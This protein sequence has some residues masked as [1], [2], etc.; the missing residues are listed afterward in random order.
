MLKLTEYERIMAEKKPMASY[1]KV[2][3]EEYYYDDR[4]K[5]LDAVE[6]NILL[7]RRFYIKNDIQ[8]FRI[9]YETYALPINYWRLE[10]YY[11]LKKIGEK[12]WNADLENMEG[13][14]LGYRGMYKEK[15]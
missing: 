12:L 1:Y 2:V 7:M 4:D 5:F 14:I 11:S 13:F 3:G 8:N 6:K 10:A 15:C 9:A